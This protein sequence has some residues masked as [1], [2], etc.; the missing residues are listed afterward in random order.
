MQPKVD[1]KM[2]M[3]SLFFDKF[4]A[5]YDEKVVFLLNTVNDLF[6]GLNS[7]AVDVPF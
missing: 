1:R 6:N 4:G 7:W 3:K 2:K 5:R